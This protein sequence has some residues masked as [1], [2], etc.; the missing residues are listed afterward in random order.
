MK[1]PGK[2]KTYSCQFWL[3]CVSS[4]FFFASFNMIIPELPAYLTK[5]G[6][7]DYKGLIISLFTLTALLS[8]PFSGKLADQ[9]GRVPVMMFG[10]LVCLVCGLLYPFL[11]TVA[12]FLLLRLV[13]GFSTGFT[14]TGQTAFLSDVIPAQRRGEAMGLLGTAG[15]VGM[16]AGPTLGGAL[17]NN[18]SF[19][20]MFYCSG[21]LGLISILVLTGIKETLPNKNRFTTSMLQIQRHEVFEKRVLVPCIVMLLTAYAY[22]TFLTIIPDFGDHIG[23]RNKGVLFGYFTIAS[24]AVRLLAG[25]ASDRYGRKSVLL[26]SVSLLIVAMCVTAIANTPFLLLTGITL[27]GLGQGMTSPTLLA[28]ATDLSDERHKG[29]GLAS[30]Y[31]FM[32]LGIGVGAL[33]S[34]TLYDNQSSGF[35]LT[36]M[37]SGILSFAALLLLLTLKPRTSAS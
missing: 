22:G 18:F 32:E 36:F 30:L 26:V 31:M 17:A 27:Y 20:V 23:V 5:L 19:D 11:T 10:S 21:V 14:P 34:A 6:G 9:L 7:A 24:L 25:R 1:E 35:M 12:G 16:A 8:R 2:K 29:R 13:H 37:A 28:W 4:F 33:L 3:I 15:T